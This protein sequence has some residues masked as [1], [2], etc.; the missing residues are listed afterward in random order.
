[1]FRDPNPGES[2]ILDGRAYTFIQ[3]DD[4][5]GIVYAEMGKKA[6]VYRIMQ[7]K[8]AYALKVFKQIY[9]NENIT[10]NTE[11]ISAYRNIP[12]LMV[13]ERSVLT[14]KK[15]PDII[16]SHPEFSYSVLM[17]WVEG[18]VWGNYI[19]GKTAMTRNECHKLAKSLVDTLYG[20]EERDIAHCDLSGGNFIFSPDYSQVELVDIEE[21]FGIGLQT[22]DPLPAGT[23]GYSPM[24][25]K[26][27]GLWEAAGDRF[28]A[29]ILLSEILGWQF[30]E[31]RAQSSNGDSFFADGEFGNETKRYELLKERLG[32][33]HSELARLLE[34]AWRATNTEECPRISEWKK[35]IGQ[36]AEQPA[37]ISWGWE[38]L[39]L[40]QDIR[41]DV[42][43]FTSLHENTQNTGQVSAPE[44]EVVAKPWSDNNHGMKSRN[45]QLARI[46]MVFIGVAIALFILISIFGN[47]ILKA[48]SD[49]HRQ[50]GLIFP[51]AISNAILGFLVGGVHSWI[52]R[53]NINKSKIGLFILSSTA[54][55]FIGGA[56]VG[57]LTDLHGINNPFLAGAVI[58]A[59]AG[60]ISSLG[61]NLFMQSQSMRLK[62]FLFN[63]VS[64]SLIWMIGTKI[65][66]DASTGLEL[67]GAATFIIVASGAALSFFLLRFPEIEF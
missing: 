64:W 26:K 9:R 20:L 10:R 67:G 41:L 24:W 21:L 61:Q 17:P 13:A 5:P 11:L 38:S 51:D 54:G 12:G 16:Q 59:I 22:P 14:P 63:L 28:A 33:L 2:I 3:V 43:P 15:Y 53:N 37:A 49:L 57:I 40:P 46:F 4:T 30:D 31:V 36:I 32:Q 7:G 60:A 8:K 1:M 29:G 42:K 18:K 58:G 50:S 47:N 39:D 55:G 48:A 56:F 23:S 19:N 45:S 66:W 44:I 52:F 62:W 65:S 27:N 35:I 25:V 34:T 6:K